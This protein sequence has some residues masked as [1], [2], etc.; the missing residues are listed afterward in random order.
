ME[1]HSPRH[2]STRLLV[3]MKNHMLKVALMI[4]AILATSNTSFAQQAKETVITIRLLDPR[5][6]TNTGDKMEIEYGDKKTDI[7]A[8]RT[9]TDAQRDELLNLLDVDLSQ[10]ECQNF[11]GH[12]P[13]YAILFR[14]KSGRILEI[15]TICGMCMTWASA[16]KRYDLKDKRSLD[17]LQKILPLPEYF[18]VKDDK[19][20][21][22]RIIFS[23]NKSTPFYAL[24]ED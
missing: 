8:S 2:R 14:N 17:L 24:K 16:G 5:V 15:K 11:C 3:E 12:Y 20:L 10:D 19:L 23:D 18:A 4:T 6:V 9:L 22:K 1:N 21:A 13:A 7:I